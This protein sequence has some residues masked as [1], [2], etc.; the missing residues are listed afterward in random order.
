[1]SYRQLWAGTWVLGV[2]P[3]S[4]GRIVSAF[5]PS[6]QD[7][8]LL[9]LKSGNIPNLLFFHPSAFNWVIYEWTFLEGDDRVSLCSPVWLWNHNPAPVSSA[10]FTDVQ[11]NILLWLPSHS[12]ANALAFSERHSSLPLPLP[13]LTCVDT[14]SCLGLWHIRDWLLYLT[15]KTST[16]NKPSVNMTGIWANDVTT[17]GCIWKLQITTIMVKT[18]ETERASGLDEV[19][20]ISQRWGS[21]GRKSPDLKPT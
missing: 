18:E 8:K 20:M 1:M 5:R 12:T 2:E 9:L 15:G 4:S 6:L 16:N 19:S 3:G 13:M 10:E 21:R 11:N 14:C 7:Q 17:S